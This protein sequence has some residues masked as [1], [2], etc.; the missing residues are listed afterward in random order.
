M[1]RVG[2]Q[3]HARG[4][5]GPTTVGGDHDRRAKLASTASRQA[6]TDDAVPVG[7]GIADGDARVHA[8][9]GGGRGIEQQ[10][11]ETPPRERHPSQPVGIVRRDLRT[12]TGH[13]HAGDR[14]AQERTPAPIPSRSRIESDPGIQRVAAQLVA[15]KRRAIDQTHAH[16][17]ARERECGDAPGRPGANHQGL[18][19]VHLARPST[20]ALFFDPKPR[21]LQSATS[22][23][24]ARG[25]FGMKSISHA[26]SGSSR[27]IVGGSTPRVMASA[28]VGDTGGAAR[29][30]RMTDHR[31]RGRSGHRVR[32]AAEDAPDALRL[33]AIVQLRRGAVVVDVADLFR[34]PVGAA[35]RGLDAAHDLRAIRIHLH[36]VIGVARRCVAFD[37]R[38]DGGT[39]RERAI[40]P[41]DHQHPRAF[42]EH[43]PVAPAIERP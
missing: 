5:S 19:L 23:S 29:A 31:L 24:A 9:A 7:D 11:I 42:T 12:G 33:D 15:R 40:F 25:A 34:T 6:H 27:L 38:I 16:A 21:Q 28:V 22:T 17:G 10:L 36:A 43:E 18:G 14:Q 3:L 13:G 37:A 39:A 1:A 2:R 41:L 8:R 32:V 20:R 4:K 30:L 35:E 26:G